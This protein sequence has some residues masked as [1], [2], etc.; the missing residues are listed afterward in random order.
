[1]P[2][3]DKLEL[4]ERP[5]V[6][7]KNRENNSNNSPKNKISI[8]QN[9]YLTEKDLEYLKLF[10]DYMSTLLDDK[11]YIAFKSPEQ[12]IDVISSLIEADPFTTRMFINT[13][14]SM[15]LVELISG[16]ILVIHKDKIKEIIK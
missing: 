2:I 4:K 11:K 15:G 5:P 9:R 1:M 3:G 10:Y 12:L 6:I 16:R 8:S 7:L 14:R 13:L